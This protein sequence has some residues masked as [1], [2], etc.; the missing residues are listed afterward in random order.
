[1]P[2]VSQNTGSSPG[3]GGGSNSSSSDSSEKEV[4]KCIVKFFPCDGWKGEYGFDWFRTEDDPIREEVDEEGTK[5]AAYYDCIG[6]YTGGKVRELVYTYDKEGEIVQ[7]KIETR[8][9]DALVFKEVPKD[10]QFATYYLN[11]YKAQIPVVKEGEKFFFYYYVPEK[12][13]VK[14]V[15]FRYNYFDKKEDHFYDCNYEIEYKGTSLKK[16]TLTTSQ[17]HEDEEGDYV[18]LKY[19]ATFG[20]GEKSKAKSKTIRKRYHTDSKLIDRI[21]DCK[22]MFEQSLGAHPNIIEV[23]VTPYSYKKMEVHL[24]KGDKKI[25]QTLEFENRK[26]FNFVQRTDDEAKHTVDIVSGIGYDRAKKKAQNEGVEDFLLD[27][28]C[29]L[30]YLPDIDGVVSGIMTI[31]NAEGKKGELNVTKEM[32]D[33]E[34]VL[35][36][37]LE[38][39]SEQYVLHPY[40]KE[41]YNGRGFTYKLEGDSQHLRHYYFYPTLNLSY[42]KG[43]GNYPDFKK[44]AKLQV[45][46]DGEFDE[47]TLEPT[48]ENIEVSPKTLKGNGTVTVKVK[49]DTYQDGQKYTWSEPEIYARSEGVMVGKLQMFVF[50]EFP[51]DP[52]NNCL[53]I[54]NVGMKASRFTVEDDGSIHMKHDLKYPS[55]ASMNTQR[56]Y[57]L[58]NEHFLR[59]LAQTGVRFKEVTTD[60][61]IDLE[62]EIV[63]ESEKDGSLDY[64]I[65]ATEM[66]M[67]TGVMVDEVPDK[68]LD[69]VYSARMF[70]H[71][72]VPDEKFEDARTFY[73][74]PVATRKR[75]TLKEFIDQRVV[76]VYYTLADHMRVYLVDQFLTNNEEGNAHRYYDEYTDTQPESTLVFI[77]S[78]DANNHAKSNVVAHSIFKAIKLKD[79][80]NNYN[81]FTFKAGSTTNIMDSSQVRYSLM[82]FQWVD[83]HLAL[84][85]NFKHIIPVMRRDYTLSMIEAHTTP[86][87]VEEKTNVSL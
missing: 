76:S 61:K 68:Y 60:K 5:A 67:V 34:E 71:F 14:T 52:L 21:Y 16:L 54:V 27:P 33:G 74:E 4:K 57:N 40:W 8:D 12:G 82:P 73:S 49:G 85:Q 42:F 26:L 41:Y 45:V 36:A 7:R 78:V 53:D 6:K 15:T 55:E 39:D 69:Y 47:I 80:F 13:D 87:N 58:D 86:S 10:Q 31:H 72:N 3:G 81:D 19:V 43:M 9:S 11:N 2:G 24:Q 70:E 66:D 50:D 83:F 63:G 18:T 79:L 46:I 29:T 25:T 75:P 48:H 28:D 38:G 64:G 84:I 62:F 1:M 35:T 23:K 77:K 56:T 30:G 32:V 17:L 22:Q 59:L 37:T 65:S 20:P 44:E 51:T